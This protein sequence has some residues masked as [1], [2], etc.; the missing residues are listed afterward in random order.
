VAADVGQALRQQH[1]AGGLELDAQ[2]AKCRWQGER[3][4]L[5]WA[6]D[7]LHPRALNERADDAIDPGDLSNDSRT[8]A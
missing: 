4:N 7:V 5:R 1:E 2:T 8:D 6:I 3:L